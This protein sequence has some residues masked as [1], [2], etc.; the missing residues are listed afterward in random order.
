MRAKED[1]GVE[2]YDRRAEIPF[3]FS[4]A[5]ASLRAAVASRGREV[6]T[7]D[8]VMVRGRSAS[9]SSS[10]MGVACVGEARMGRFGSD[11]VEAGYG[12]GDL[13]V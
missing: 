12:V 11:I 1:C 5:P 3:G 7:T 6:R 4:K 9:W 13:R 10:G 8:A 2:N